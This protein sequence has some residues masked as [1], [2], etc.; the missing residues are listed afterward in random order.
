M[1]NIELFKGIV[2]M[3]NIITKIT[4]MN[5]IVSNGIFMWKE[6]GILSILTF[7][8]KLEKDVLPLL[9][10]KFILYPKTI[11]IFDK[12]LTLSNL[13]MTEYGVLLEFIGTLPQEISS[14]Y[15]LLS[16][17][18]NVILSSDTLIP[19]S[20]VDLIATELIHITNERILL[21]LP[22]IDNSNSQYS[23]LVETLTSISSNAD[24]DNSIY[25]N[26]DNN[27][28]L[29][30]STR[31][32]EI[33]IGELYLRIAKSVFINVNKADKLSIRCTPFKNSSDMYLITTTNCKEKSCQLINLMNAINI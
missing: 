29:S 13:H 6:S 20:D 33:T 31:A 26:I 14:D 17:K 9:D 19:D 28:T 21:L 27:D 7:V 1:N 15:Y 24:F 5:I 3:S 18:L 25:Y 8:Q 12:Y 10:K 23:E 16:S 4:S 30:A 11:S 32:I 22:F 2:N